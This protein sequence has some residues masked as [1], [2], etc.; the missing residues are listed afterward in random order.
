MPQEL[1]HFAGHAFLKMHG[2]GNDFVVLDLRDGDGVVTP[3]LARR[4]GDRRT[5]IGFDQ[6][7]VIGPAPD[8]GNGIETDAGITFWNRDGTMAEAC[9]NGTRCAARLLMDEASVSAL[10]LGTARGR[11]LAERS[12]GLVRINMGQPAVSWADIPLARDMP[13][14]P[15][16]ID[17]APAAIGMGNPHCVFVVEDAEAVDLT[18]RGPLIETDPLFPNATNVEF[19]HVA[20]PDR[21]RM[22]VWERSTGVTQACGSGA[23]AAAVVAAMRGLTGRS[24]DVELDGGMLHI[25]WRDDG[26][27]MTG[28]TMIVCEGRLSAEFLA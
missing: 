7:V 18:T 4:I 19:I 25:D 22:R 1:D 5:G 3:E 14:D 8:I 9:G 12:D 27:W 10:S 15:L 17:G 16:P 6:L 23:C 21:L 2:L 11:L 28:P 13:T 20:G 24:V 26:I